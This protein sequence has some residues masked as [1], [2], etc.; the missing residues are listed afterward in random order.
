M[1]TLAHSQV[2]AEKD[3]LIEAKKIAESEKRLYVKV[4]IQ[5]S[6]MSPKIMFLSCSVVAFVVDN[7]F[8][9]N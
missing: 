2:K 8:Q 3:R 4:C 6:K 5:K 1:S 9:S 7:W